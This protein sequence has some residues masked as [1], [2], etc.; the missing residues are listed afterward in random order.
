MPEI[1]EYNGIA[2]ADIASI[3]GQDVPSGSGGG[4]YATASTGLLVWGNDGAPTKPFDGAL[5]GAASVP[6]SYPLF[7]PPSGRYVT[8]IVFTRPGHCG[9]LLDNGDVYTTGTVSQSYMGRNSSTTPYNEFGLSLTGVAKLA[10]HYIGFMAIKTNGTLWY[11]G[12]VSFYF[13]GS[14]TASQMWRQYGTDTDWVDVVGHTNYPYTSYY[15]KGTG[16][17]KRLYTSGYNAYGMT[18]LGTTSGTTTTPTLMKTDASTNFTDVPDKFATGGTAFGVINT[19]GELFTCGRGTYGTTG[20]GTSSNTTYLTQ[21]GTATDWELYWPGALGAFGIRN[22]ALYG[23]VSNTLYYEITYQLSGYSATRT[24][25][26]IGTETDFEEIYGW[27]FSQSYTDSFKGLIVKR[28]SGWYVNGRNKSGWNGAKGIDL[29]AS[30]G[31]WYDL[32]S[33]TNLETPVGSSYTIRTAAVSHDNFN[34]QAPLG[35]YLSVS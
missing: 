30:P 12:Q 3:N 21:V 8:Q 31:T 24:F 35:I 33:S 28:T 26:Q 11:T 32:T 29:L 16:T 14:S 7:T 13:S 25:S 6:Q 22:G 23:S 9:I 19:S 27:D 1:S 10:P 2:M 17:G 4:G 20:Q 5:F 34:V 15:M 18:G